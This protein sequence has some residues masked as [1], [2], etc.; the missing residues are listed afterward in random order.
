MDKIINYAVQ[1]KG[2]TKIVPKTI[3][4]DGSDD[5]FYRY[6]MRQLY[7]QVVGRGKMIKTVLLNVDDVAKDLKIPPQYMNAYMGYEIGANTKYDSK[8]PDR[9]RAFIS[10]E[11]ESAQISTIMKKFINDV[12]LCERCKLPEVTLIIE[13]GVIINVCRSCGARTV[14]NNLKPRF[15]QY[16]LHNPVDANISKNEMKVRTKT[17]SFCSRST[18]SE[19]IK[20]IKKRKK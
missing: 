3:N 13:D 6:K 4:I 19:I 15:E 10:G 14:L 7:L 20:E 5:P 12:I 9:E 11:Y 8:K 1:T 18:K 2:D 16:I 17:G